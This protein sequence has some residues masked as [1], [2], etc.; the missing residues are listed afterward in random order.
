M[1]QIKCDGSN[2]KKDARNT[3]MDMAGQANKTFVFVIS[4]RCKC[5]TIK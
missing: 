2:L 1:L 3:D 4:Y 5:R